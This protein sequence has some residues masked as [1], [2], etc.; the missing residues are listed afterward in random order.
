[1]ECGHFSAQGQ[2][3]KA[4]TATDAALSSYASSICR[5]KA[6]VIADCRV[7]PPRAIRIVIVN[8]AASSQVD[9]DNREYWQPGDIEVV[10]DR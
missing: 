1:M 10:E 2:A 3:A 8:S 4:H 9:S 7:I 6:R 5:D